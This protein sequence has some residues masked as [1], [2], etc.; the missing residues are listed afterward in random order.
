MLLYDYTANEGAPQFVTYEFETEELAN[1]STYEFDFN[2]TNWVTVTKEVTKKEVE[3]DYKVI[4]TWLLTLT[5]KTAVLNTSRG[6]YTN[7]RIKSGDS[8]VLTEEILQTGK[9]KSFDISERLKFRY[10]GTPLTYKEVT[11][12]TCF[13]PTSSDITESGSYK[14]FSSTELTCDISTANLVKQDGEYYYPVTITVTVSATSDTEVK[15]VSPLKVLAG[16]DVVAT[17]Y[18]MQYALIPT[19]TTNLDS[20]TQENV[21]VTFS[22]FNSTDWGSIDIVL[23]DDTAKVS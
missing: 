22:N 1:N 14:S 4:T 6:R 10:D 23:S 21:G 7:I 19:V 5:V 12:D 15:A 9:A 3:K 20:S 16:S 13:I 2:T 17:F 11:F 18:V 8:Y